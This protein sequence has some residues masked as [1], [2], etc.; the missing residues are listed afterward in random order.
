MHLK[1]L[2]VVA[3]LSLATPVIA[4][5]TAAAPAAPSLSTRLPIDP[6]LRIGKL[7]NGL[8]YYI[9]QNTRPEKR[10][11]LRL[12]VNAGSVLEPN[13]KLGLAH[14]LEHTAFNGT[15]HFAKNDLV[16]YLE[17]IGVRFG[18][19]LNA[20]TSFD[21]TVYILPIPTDTA[22][23]VDQ[24]FTILEDWAHGQTF[25]PTEVTNERGVVREEWRGRKGAGDRMLQ[26]W[27]PVAF[28]GSRYAERL[29]IGTEASIMA[30]TPEKLRTFYQTWYRPDLMAVIA[31]GDFDPAVIEAKIKQHFSGLKNPAN[32]QKRTLYDVPTNAEPLVA[33]ASDKE[34][35]SSSVNL[36]YKLDADSVN[37]VGDYRKLL[38]ERLYLS[39]LNSR[40][41]EIAEKPDAPFLAA[42]ASKD[43]F[44]ARTTEAFTLAANVKDGGIEKAAEALLTEARRVDQFGFL[45]SELDRQKTNTLRS[46]ERAFAE[47]DKTQSES[48]VEEYIG[49]YLQGES[50]PGIEY[51]Y[52]ITQELLPTI[53]LADI[54]NLAK[55]WITDENRVVIAQSPIKDGVA[56]PT[57]AGILAAFDKAS[58]ATL[59]A[60]TETVSSDNLVDKAPAAGK[61][62]SSTPLASIGAVEWK[63]SNGA[64]VII[65]P[66]DFKADEVL[67]SAYSPGGTSLASDSDYMSAALASQVMQLGG[68]G[69]FS[70][71]DLGKRLAGKAAG[72]SP[73][74]GETT[75]GLSGRSSPKD[76]E[77]MFQLAYLS[78]T[79]PRLDTVVFTTFRGQAATVLANRGLSPE[80]VFGDTIQ[81]TLAQH[82]FRARPLTPQVFDEVNAQKALAFYK[83]R[84]AN[85]SDFTFVL[86]GNVDTVAIKPMVETYLA[87][88]PNTGRVEKAKDV[89]ITPP[90]GFVERIVH[91][92]TE[93]K[94]STRLVFTGTC[95]YTPQDRFALRALTTLMQT[96]LNESLRERL[97]GTYSPS[98]GGSCQR[99]P[100]QEYAVSVAFGSSPENVEVLSKA[101]M[102][103]IDSL[104]AQPVP[105]ADVDKVKEEILRSREVE[106]KTNAYWLGNIAAR[107]QAGEDLAG[108]G[109]A[110]DEMVKKL[111]PAMIQAAA[112]K[113]FDTS[114]Y[115]RFVLLPETSK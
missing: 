22:R 26:Q 75:E 72:V 80:Q 114:N 91:K 109:P 28:K 106:V 70:R 20:Y 111:T 59:A 47:R 73:T 11:E 18:A 16:K 67:F 65:K 107:D 52:K 55:K 102:A 87:S 92:G 113:Y 68:L 58:K 41:A 27:L 5:Q 98:V 96:R 101:T 37:T 57:K 60:W 19:D 35:T 51:E 77:T 15:K 25:D 49:N 110:Y 8:Q 54:N 95:S 69:S 94:A 66:T 97:G 74:I 6:K 61:I 40:F 24:A 48:F 50:I 38:M 7:P 76:I 31:V 105:Q 29:P 64:R 30:A 89:G 108:L 53:T 99:E 23:I 43:A 78:F 88:L 103:L 83:D 9:R 100:R 115:A 79:A 42:G 10:A 62:V 32:E 81:V 71:I 82:A 14:F 44:F 33:I 17:S 2:S 1:A 90:K 12:V 36:I 84:F 46:Y 112:K 3:A 85:A 104:K 21:E 34:A 86:V 56:Q 4:Q 39:M 63:L 45:Q 93:P 13:D